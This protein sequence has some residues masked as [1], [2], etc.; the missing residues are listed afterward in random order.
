[1]TT[2]ILNKVSIAWEEQT[3]KDLLKNI[4]HYDIRLLDSLLLP[5]TECAEMIYADAVAM[6]MTSNDYR[7]GSNL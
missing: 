5:S 4:E 3:R 1:M 6:V 7:S 2:N